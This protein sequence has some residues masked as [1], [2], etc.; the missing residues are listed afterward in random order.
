MSRDDKPTIGWALSLGILLVFSPIGF[1]LG[2]VSDPPWGWSAGVVSA[3]FAGSLALGWSITFRL[4]KYWMVIPL[5]AIPIL[6]GPFFFTPLFRL[7]VMNIGTGIDPV[8]RRIILAV[9]SIAAISAGFT[10]IVSHLR[11]AEKRAERHRTEMALAGRIHQS[12]VPQLARRSSA[13][14]IFGRSEPSSEIGGDLI[15]LVEHGGTIDLYLAD[16]S[17]H[18]VRA[19]VL[20]A[21]VKSAIRTRLLDAD[22]ASLPLADAA[23]HLNRVVAQVSDSDMFA[24]FACLRIGPGRRVEYALAG[25]LPILHISADGRVREFENESLPLGIDPE[26]A[27]DSRTVEVQPGDVLAILTDGLVEAQN[28]SGRQFGME[29]IRSSLAGVAGLPLAE[30]YAA[31]LNAVRAHGTQSDDQTLLLARIV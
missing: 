12:L 9:L 7:G 16:V 20:M 23:R 4:R 29:R 18:G 1:L 27:F 2:L 14:E 17:G 13:V 11:T 5:L 25:H 28:A 15:D 10:L 8:A 24:T 31:L 21:M 22:A 30:I 6:A 19:G 26:E 3:I